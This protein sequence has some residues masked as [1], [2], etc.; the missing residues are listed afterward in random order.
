MEILQTKLFSSNEEFTKWQ[1]EAE[2]KITQITPV[3]QSISAEQVT[4]YK[5]YIEPASYGIFVVYWHDVEEVEIT[6]E[7]LEKALGITGV[8][9]VLVDG[10]IVYYSYTEAPIINLTDAHR[11]NLYELKAKL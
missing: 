11:V 1:L 9:D 10:S 5:Q 6:I 8:V 2:R 3:Y 7:K 4:D